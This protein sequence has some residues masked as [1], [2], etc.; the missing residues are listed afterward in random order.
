[1]IGKQADDYA[2]I[3]ILGQTVAGGTRRLFTAFSKKEL[4]ADVSQSNVWWYIYINMPQKNE[5]AIIFVILAQFYNNQIIVN[6][7]VSH[8]IVKSL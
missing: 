4:Y 2:W 1:M 8:H 7:L 6:L 3:N 5:C